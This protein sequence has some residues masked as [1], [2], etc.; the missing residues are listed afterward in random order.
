VILKIET[1]KGKERTSIRLIGRVR[2]EALPNLE[3]EVKGNAR[4]VALVM[5]E[6][7]LVDL[8]VVRFLSGCES[9]GIELRGCPPY[10]RQW[11][12]Q[13]KQSGNP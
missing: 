11:I 7:T 9:Q 3:A 8:D 5:D 1:I 4:V 13:E 10:I 2:A 6:V 12:A